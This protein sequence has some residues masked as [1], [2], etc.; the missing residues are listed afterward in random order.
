MTRKI[1]AIFAALLLTASLC[2][3]SG[4]TNNEETSGDRIDINIETN[5]TNDTSNTDTNETEDTS[6]SESATETGDVNVELTFTPFDAPQT[7]YVLHKNGAV[8]IRTAPNYEAD[9]V[10]KSLSNG[11]EL[12]RVAISE[13][14]EWSRIEYEG[15]EYYIGSQCLTTLADITAGFVAVEKTYTVVAASVNVRIAP[16][17]TEL[18]GEVTQYN[19]I[20]SIA[21]G[22][23][24]KVIAENTSIG[25][26][27]IEFESEYTGPAF[28]R[29]NAD[30]FEGDEVT[31]TEGYALYNDDS[32]SFEYP[33]NWENMN[34]NEQIK[35]NSVTGDNVSVSYADYTSEYD[36][37][38]SM[39]NESFA[40]TFIPVYES[41]GYVISDYN[42]TLTKKGNTDVVIIVFQNVVNGTPM[43]QTQVF[44]VVGSGQFCTITVTELNA[45]AHIAAEIYESLNIK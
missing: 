37:Y 40:E 1:I 17:V 6:D 25:W 43:Y 21:E 24:V 7:V 33:E 38:F 31:V 34:G 45:D 28:V 18:N 44:G 39:T 36:F 5:D 22:D 23:T 11:T 29:Y 35:W 26:I 27:Q 30:W 12:K 19:V 8:N 16:E 15:K 41:M 42:V 20:G 14:D 4:N 9:T 3:C 10:Y 2:A 32:I 13:G